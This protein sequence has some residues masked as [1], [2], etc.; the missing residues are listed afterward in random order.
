L[1][2]GGTDSEVQLKAGSVTFY[3]SAPMNQNIFP[4]AVLFIGIP[5]EK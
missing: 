1:E 5:P 4:K 2:E 3:I